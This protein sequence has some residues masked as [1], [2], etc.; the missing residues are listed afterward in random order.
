MKDLTR[1]AKTEMRDQICA[2]DA[3]QLVD[4]VCDEKEK[5]HFKF[6]A[7]GLVNQ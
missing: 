3:N 6:L 4:G 5:I 1:S 7:K 2:N